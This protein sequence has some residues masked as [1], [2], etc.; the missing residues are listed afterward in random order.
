MI[1][2]LAE[3]G[4]TCVYWLQKLDSVKKDP[5]VDF[6]E[7]QSLWSSTAGSMEDPTMQIERLEFLGWLWEPYHSF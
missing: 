7:T 2:L 1:R 3:I 4:I 6:H 5:P